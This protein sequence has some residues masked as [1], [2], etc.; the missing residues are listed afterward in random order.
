MLRL[1]GGTIMVLHDSTATVRRIGL[2]G[3]L[4]ITALACPVRAATGENALTPRGLAVQGGTPVLAP[5]ERDALRGIAAGVRDDASLYPT[6]E[7]AVKQKGLVPLAVA[8][9]REDEHTLWRLGLRL[10]IRHRLGPLLQTEIMTVV[11][12]TAGGLRAK[13]SLV[14]LPFTGIALSHALHVARSEDMQTDLVYRFWLCAGVMAADDRNRIWAEMALLARN[15]NCSRTL[16]IELWRALADA[17]YALTDQMVV[18]D[19]EYW[20]L[21]KDLDVGPDNEVRALLARRSVDL[22]AQLVA[23]LSSDDVAARTRSAFTL[24]SEFHEPK[25]VSVLAK[26][27]P[28]LETPMVPWGSVGYCAL[29]GLMRVDDGTLLK[30]AVGGLQENDTVKATLGAGR[31]SDDVLDRLEE[32]LAPSSAVALRTR[33]DLATAIAQWLAKNLP[34]AQWYVSKP[35]LRV[36][37]RTL[38]PQP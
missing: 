23:F 22:H 14:Q 34:N 35:E 19:E 6:L 38:C 17:R 33:K 12:D 2:V 15:N 11:T 16:R 4:A 18:G 36:I 21:G 20:R 10:I 32:V 5:G 24:A 29:Q 31:T 1:M 28:Y 9:F 37:E 3:V 7:S 25:A 8:L 27:L 13:E 30:A 26:G